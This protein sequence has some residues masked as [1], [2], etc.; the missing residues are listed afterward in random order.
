M[1]HVSYPI[2]HQISFHF[3][4]MY[5]F[6]EFLSYIKSYHIG[7]WFFR[8]PQNAKNPEISD[9]GQPE[10][11]LD[12]PK[13]VCWWSIYLHQS[14]IAVVYQ[15]RAI[16]LNL[17]KWI[18]IY[19][20]L[21]DNCWHLKI[22]FCWYK[23]FL[24][25]GSSCCCFFFGGGG[26]MFIVYSNF[27]VNHPA[28]FQRAKQLGMMYFSSKWESAKEPR[29]FHE[30]LKITGIVQTSFASIS[31]SS[32]SNNLKKNG[33]F[34][35]LCCWDPVTFQRGLWLTPGKCFSSL[36]LWRCFAHS[37]IYP[38]EAENQPQRKGRDEFFACFVRISF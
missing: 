23:H 14:T 16:Y 28:I 19:T 34:K 22:P 15:K 5:H 10:R 29:N 7:R 24:L 37:K 17:Y 36:K 30:I 6:T 25:M 12:S 33:D 18:Y 9:L 2:I 31:R 13:N 3:I 27:G 21:R 38:A 1:H 20:P 11:S 4:Y 26:G 8:V 32:R 35:R